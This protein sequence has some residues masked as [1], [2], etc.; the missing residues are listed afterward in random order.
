MTFKTSPSACTNFVC[1]YSIRIFGWRSSSAMIVRHA[2]LMRHFLRL[3]RQ[4][5]LIN[6]CLQEFGFA[7]DNRNCYSL[8]CQLII[9]VG[10]NH[11]M[12]SVCHGSDGTCKKQFRRKYAYSSSCLKWGPVIQSVCLARVV[13]CVDL[14]N[15]SCAVELPTSWPDDER[16]RN[17]YLSTLCPS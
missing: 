2:C 4:C 13:D 16:I 7:F 14:K 8:K 12:T 15:E 11:E 1:R 6:D 3:H 9:L 10:K 17:L 5:W